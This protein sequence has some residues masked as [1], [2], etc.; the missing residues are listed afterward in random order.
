MKDENIKAKEEA[1]SKDIDVKVKYLLSLSKRLAKNGANIS[2]DNMLQENLETT[3]KTL[4]TL[5]NRKAILESYSMK[6]EEV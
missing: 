4:N 5:I 1:L 3:T 2:E 6:I